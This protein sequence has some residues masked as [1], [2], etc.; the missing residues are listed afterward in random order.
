MS[1]NAQSMN[2]QTGVGRCSEG[3]GARALV[4]LPPG[5]ILPAFLGATDAACLLSDFSIKEG[6]IQQ[7]SSA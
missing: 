1:P 3:H 2:E 4:R 6:W 7:L 5:P